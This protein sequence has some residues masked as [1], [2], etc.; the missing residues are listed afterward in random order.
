M[1]EIFWDIQNKW[2]RYRTDRTDPSARL[3]RRER[4]GRREWSRLVGFSDFRKP[5]VGI[6]EDQHWGC[7]MGICKDWT[8][9][10]G[11]IYWN[12]GRYRMT[13]FTINSVFFL[14]F[15]GIIM[16]IYFMNLRYLCQ[17]MSTSWYEKNG[18]LPENG[19][20]R[21]ISHGLA[22]FY[23]VHGWSGRFPN[24]FLHFLE[25]NSWW[26]ILDMYLRIKGRP[27]DLTF[28]EP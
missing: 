22:S 2:W 4:P 25:G 13:Y 27:L 24:P 19:E 6:N 12:M 16:G 14:W 5:S 10:Y 1:V 26:T 8:R 28:P 9:Y 20:K 3:Y 21:Y 17:H 7:N 23:R 15:N 18:P 11:E